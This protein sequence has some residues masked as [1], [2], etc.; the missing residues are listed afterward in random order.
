MKRIVSV[1][2]ALTMALLCIAACGGGSDSAIVG[3]WN[4]ATASLSGKTL[5]REEI[6]TLA[7]EMAA[8]DMWL[9]VGFAFKA[10]GTGTATYGGEGNTATLKWKA[11]GSDED[12]N[13]AETFEV[14][15]D[16]RTYG[17][18]YYEKTNNLFLL[19]GDGHMIFETTAAP[20]A[21]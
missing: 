11:T 3:E 21:E 14:E 6:T 10:G 20:S 15:L 16:G 7:D 4:V 19:S 13:D 18:E 1:V 17:L 5:T 12:N 8:Q 9:P 2:V